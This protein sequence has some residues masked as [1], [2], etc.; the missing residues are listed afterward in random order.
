MH[1]VFPTA[2]YSTVD[3]L[4]CRQNNFGNASDEIFYRV[5]CVDVGTLCGTRGLAGV[6]A[7]FCRNVTAE[8]DVAIGDIFVRTLSSEEFF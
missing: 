4:E 1:R 8:V 6:N 2:C 5:G 7:N 3:D